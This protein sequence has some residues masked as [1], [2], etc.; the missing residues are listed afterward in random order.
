MAKYQPYAAP[1]ARLTAHRAEL[2]GNMLDDP[3]LRAKLAETI[4]AERCAKGLHWPET[5]ADTGNEVCRRCNKVTD[6][7]SDVFHPDVL[8][9]EETDGP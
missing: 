8:A 7:Y 4:G 6:D 3:A 1:Y 9:Q 2:A 5:D